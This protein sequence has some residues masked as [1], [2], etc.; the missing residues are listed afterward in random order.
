MTAKGEEP[1]RGVRVAPVHEVERPDEFPVPGAEEVEHALLAVAAEAGALPTEELIARVVQRLGASADDRGVVALVEGIEEALTDEFGPLAWMS[2]D[3]TAHVPTLCEGIV[4]THVLSDAERESGALQVSFDLAGFVHV[5]DPTVDGE[6][7]DAI[8]A[9]PGHLMWIGPEGWL[10]RFAP[11]TVLAVRVDRDERIDLEAIREPAPV[12]PA[13]VAAVRRV[14]DATTAE[15]RL[16]VSG[17]ELV[18]GL[19]V[20]DRAACS[21][22][23]APLS[24]LCEAA[25]LERRGSFVAHDDEVWANARRFGRIAR[26]SLV[27]EDDRELAVRVLDSLEAFDALATDTADA[28][29][30][31]QI[32]DV[33]DRLADI[34]ALALVTDELFGDAEPLEDVG[35]V[36]ARLIAAARTP[37][38]RATARYLAAL[39]AEAED[40]WATAEQHLELALEAD[41]SNLPVLDRVAWYASDRGDAA[42]AVRLWRR[43]PRSAS[44]AEDLACVEPFVRPTASVVGRNEPCWC[45]SGRKYKHCHLGS[46]APVPLPDRVHWLHRKAIGYVERIGPA[47][48]A[49]LLDV[50]E[51][52]MGEDDDLEAVMDD[53][54]VVDLVLTEGGWFDRFLAHRG[55]L[56]PEDEALL[57]AVWMAVERTV[58]EITAVTPGEGLSVRDLRTGRELQ[59][60]ERTYSRL[61]EVGLLVC[62]RAVPDGV[63]S[64]FVGAVLPVVPGTEAAVLDLLDDA[65]PLEIAAWA[66][67]VSEILEALG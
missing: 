49:D 27:A 33:L 32:T 13:S 39:A 61:A 19:L 14:Y 55:H 67:E 65:D 62:A 60:R 26:L 22:L 10:D 15:T 18:L 1:P 2:G 42:R 58:Y 17:Q 4:L 28:V 66:R 24:A 9:E 59:V 57:A 50:I 7:V 23:R 16:P 43:C 31:A 30:E 48:R 25:G 34:E 64:Q 8:S 37:S 35:G 3:R 46:A 54:L 51:A 56:L 45:G 47:A 36:A 5:V 44:V 52:R 38:Q 40:D 41:P 21:V 29:D 63:T 20:E 53:P 12:D 6:G 11:D